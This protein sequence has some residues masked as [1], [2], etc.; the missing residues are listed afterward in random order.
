MSRKVL[1]LLAAAGL[2]ASAGAQA[3]SKPKPKL[4][5]YRDAS[6][7]VAIRLP[8]EW[9]VNAVVGRS[10]NMI[11]RLYPKI[12][13]IDD[14]DI[15][16]SLREETGIVLPL[17]QAHLDLPFYVESMQSKAGKVVRKPVPHLIADRD[18]DPL[19]V[20]YIQVVAY[21]RFRCRGIHVGLHCKAATFDRIR[22]VFFAAVR[23]VTC[24]LPRW[25][26]MP[27][28]G[29]RHTVRDTIAYHLGEGVG[30]RAIKRMHRCVLAV[31]KDFVRFHGRIQRAKDEPL[32]IVVHKDPEQH[33]KL[34]KDAADQAWHGVFVDGPGKRLLAVPYQ[35]PGSRAEAALAWGVTWIL[36]IE[37]YGNL[38]PVWAWRGEQRL[39]W[40]R[41]LTGKRAPYVTEAWRS[42]KV[43]LG[44]TL[45][46]LEELRVSRFQEYQSH[47][48]AYALLFRA[49]PAR[50]RRAYKAFLGDYARIGDY[51]AALET[52]L[53][54]LDQDQLVRD[55]REFVEKKLKVPDRK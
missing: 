33:T 1:V 2:L 35:R 54:S 53:L 17:A 30:D 5:E 23:S 19:Y 32:M 43:T 18:K 44:K 3:G 20:G 51:K 16:M 28:A 37:R 8:G 45:A 39:A 25:P 4:K 15:R 38:E 13:G 10:E 21:R 26:V 47:G 7:K 14:D 48:E 46:G 52:R 31:E 11:L 29:Y 27:A 49:G 36:L 6:G 12:S 40:F 55:L 34:D 22:G 50:Y 41:I 42:Q 24:T 9:K